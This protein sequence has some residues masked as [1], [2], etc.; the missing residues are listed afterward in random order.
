M[1]NLEV[2]TRFTAIAERGSFRAAAAALYISQPTLSRQIRSLEEELGVKLFDRGRWGTRLTEEGERLV[3]LARRL[4]ADVAGLRALIRPG[5]QVVVR[6]GAAS[7]AV[8]SFLAPFIAEWGRDRALV[9]LELI[10][11]G[12]IALR[13]R[14]SRG[15]CDIALLAPP[16]PDGFRSRPVKNFAL[17]A[18]FPK[19]HPL[20]AAAGPVPLATVAEHPLLINASSFI[21]SEVL[22]AAFRL[23]G[24]EPNIAYESIS[25]HTLA[26]LAE[27][28]GGV[29]VIADTVDLRG[30]DLLQRPIVL[31][32]GRGIE[33][34]LHLAWHATL[35]DRPEIADFVEQFASFVLSRSRHVG[36]FPAGAGRGH[37][38]SAPISANPKLA[39]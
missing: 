37:A 39:S 26:A 25:G 3:P 5:Q 23:E 28:G 12:S 14:L 17:R 18:H 4:I 27:N 6:V 34:V 33:F 11:D 35:T 22:E 36:G 1:L 19:D 16:I 38:D 10:E 32:D 9:H 24:L 2:I 31:P 20:A 8:G 13:A 15:E 21:A 30:Y 29:A 7:T